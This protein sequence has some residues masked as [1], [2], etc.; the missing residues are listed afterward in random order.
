MTDL[1]KLNLEGLVKCYISNFLSII[2]EK[3]VVGLEEFYNE[4]IKKIADESKI[5]A[6]VIKYLHHAFHWEFF[7]GNPD[8]PLEI[9]S[10]GAPEGG[11][12]VRLKSEANFDYSAFSKKFLEKHKDYLGCRIESIKSNN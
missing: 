11:F 4:A 10:N 8:S 5:D 3:K 12:Y 7:C 6:Q 1:D 9:F 2:K